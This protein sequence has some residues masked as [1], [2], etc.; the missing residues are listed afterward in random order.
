M[1]VQLENNVFQ[2]QSL[3]C[4]CAFTPNAENV[5]PVLLQG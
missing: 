3:K 2:K 1:D 4:N 5:K